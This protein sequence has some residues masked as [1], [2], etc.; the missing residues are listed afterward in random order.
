MDW[1][2]VVIVAAVFTTLGFVI[3]I[4]IGWTQADTKESQ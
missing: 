4:E 2:T 3:G 1:T